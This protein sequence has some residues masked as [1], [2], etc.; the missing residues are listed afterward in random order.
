[1]DRQKKLIK[2][3]K[4]VGIYCLPLFLTACYNQTLYHSYQPVNKTGWYQNDTILFTL[5]QPVAVNSIHEYIIGIRHKDSYQFRDL[6]LKINQDTIHLYLANKNGSWFGHGIG[7]IKQI[8][9]P[10]TLK[11]T[12]DS[13][14]DIRIVHIMQQNPLLNLQ[15]IGISIEKLN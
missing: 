10:F 8:T 1:M 3:L 9:F 6:W 2:L 7:E 11:S 12:N 13:I 5:K 4:Y 15:D 14:I